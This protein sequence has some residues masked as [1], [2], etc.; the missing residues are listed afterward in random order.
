[1]KAGYFTPMAEVLCFTCVGEDSWM[2]DED[3]HES[4]CQTCGA[5][6][7]LSREDV[8][9][10]RNFEVA[11]QEELLTHDGIDDARVWQTGGMCVAFGISFLGG[12]HAL[13]T[14]VMDEDEATYGKYIL[15]FYDDQAGMIEDDVHYGDGPTLVAKILK[16][17]TERN[18]P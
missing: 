5:A 8:A 11:H 18:Q 14:E 3:C 9:L 13:V 2:R 7:Y 16:H 15:G 17:A 1:M 10:C 6:I 12:T 4:N